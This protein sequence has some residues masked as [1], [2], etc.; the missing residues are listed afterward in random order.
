M[1]KNF[2]FIKNLKNIKFENSWKN[3][4]SSNK[5]NNLKLLKSSDGL[6][7]VMVSTMMLEALHFSMPVLALSTNYKNHGIYNW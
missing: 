6:I 4:N 5:K 7:S 1:V 2:E 3:F